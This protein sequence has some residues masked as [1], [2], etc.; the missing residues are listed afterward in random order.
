MKSASVDL[1]DRLSFENNVHN[2]PKP[3]QQQDLSS[4]SNETALQIKSENI[5]NDA[6]SLTDSDSF[7]N[8]NLSCN[9][10]N[11]LVSTSGDK[12][13]L[14]ANV[15][16]TPS[17]PS[18]CKSDNDTV[19]STENEN[20]NEAKSGQDYKTAWS[21]RAVQTDDENCEAASSNSV[22]YNAMFPLV[23]DDDS[24]SVDI[25]SNKVLDYSENNNDNECLSLDDR[26]EVT[27]HQHHHH[28]TTYTKAQNQ[29]TYDT[30]DSSKEYQDESDFKSDTATKNN[31]VSL[32]NLKNS[33]F[34]K[35]R[36]LTSPVTIYDN[37]TYKTKNK[38]EFHQVEIQV[39][40]MHPIITFYLS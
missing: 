13:N 33:N 37:V 31:R 29:S 35:N 4:N 28:T 1:D 10:K 25:D 19:N 27:D 32:K 34:I 39:E 12:K 23:K 16:S 7:K 40:E 3:Q 6:I 9:N 38:V 26:T 21:P 18:E 14:G 36:D 24:R 17:S 2:S 15:V 30:E 11:I 22:P 8:I 5:P 20:S